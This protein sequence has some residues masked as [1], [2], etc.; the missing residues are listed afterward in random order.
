[1]AET[2]YVLCALTS[3]ACTALLLRSYAETRVRLLLWSGLCFAGLALNNVILFVD[4]VV[5]PDVDLSLVRLPVR[6]LRARVHGFRVQPRDT[7]DPR[8]GQR[9]P[10]VRL[11][12]ATGGIRVDH[13]RDSR[14]EPRR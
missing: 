2:V 8:R 11:P 12:P 7:D 1:M 13:R 6:D 5:A 14:Q 3:L 9:G 4:K 10:A